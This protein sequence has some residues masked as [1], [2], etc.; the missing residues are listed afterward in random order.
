MTSKVSMSAVDEKRLKLL[1]S[2]YLSGL[3]LHSHLLLVWPA[4]DLLDV[5]QCVHD[6]FAY[7]RY[8]DRTCVAPN[9][10]AHTT[11]WRTRKAQH[12]FDVPREPA[13][14]VGEDGRLV[15]PELYCNLQASSACPSDS[16]GLPVEGRSG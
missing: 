5:L 14:W 4:A 15:V 13:T 3:H 11:V 12:I 1:M 16:S 2:S 10:D 6:Q 7:Q 8:R 9:V